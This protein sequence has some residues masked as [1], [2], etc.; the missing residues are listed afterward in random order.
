[1]SPLSS[2]EAT[3]IILKHSACCL[4]GSMRTDSLYFMDFSIKEGSMD[5]NIKNM[6]HFL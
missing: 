4:K 5:D 2:A 6:G 3:E 1:M